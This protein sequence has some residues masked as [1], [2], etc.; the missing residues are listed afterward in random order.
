[1]DDSDDEKAP[2]APEAPAPA[3]PAAPAAPPPSMPADRGDIG[4]QVR[5]G[6]FR[7]GSHENIRA[8]TDTATRTVA[9]RAVNSGA[10]GATGPTNLSRTPGERTPPG[11]TPTGPVGPLG[12]RAA[13]VATATIGTG[14]AP[15]FTRDD[16]PTNTAIQNRAQLD[17]GN[18]AA[19][20]A[21]GSVAPPMPLTGSV[22]P[23]PP[24][25]PVT[26]AAAAPDDVPPTPAA[27][28][29]ASLKPI[30]GSLDVTL[31]DVT[32]E[33]YVTDQVRQKVQLERG[34]AL[35]TQDGDRIVT[36][37]GDA[38]LTEDGEGDW[39]PAPP[40]PATHTVAAADDVPVPPTRTG[41]AAGIENLSG[42][43][44]GKASATGPIGSRGDLSGRA[45]GTS[46]GTGIL[47][48]AE[49]TA[50]V[51]GPSTEARVAPPQDRPR[52]ES[53][54]DQPS[55]FDKIGFE[56][57]VDGLAQFLMS[58][59][60]KPPL[61]VSLEGEWGAGKSSFMAQLKKAIGRL[62][63][64]K[65]AD[66]ARPAKP[67][68]GG[69]VFVHAKRSGGEAPIGWRGSLPPWVNGL[70]T[71]CWQGLKIALWFAPKDA[72]AEPPRIIEFNAWRH[73]K[74]EAV[75]ASFAL[76]F[77][78]SA[79]GT[80]RYDRCRLAV[81]LAVK[82]FKWVEALPLLIRAGAL[83]L[84]GAAFV[85]VVG[86]LVFYPTLGD[87]S[88]ASL[89]TGW[90]DYLK[91]WVPRV[92]VASPIATGLLAALRRLLAPPLEIDLKKYLEVPAYK[93]K[94]SFLERFH[95][96]FELF[97]QTY[98]E[99]RR[100][101]VLVDDLDRC[102][103]T[104]GA[105]LLQ[106][107][108]MMLP[109]DAP[110][111]LIL[112]LDRRKLAIGVAVRNKDVLPYVGADSAAALTS[113]EDELRREMEPAAHAALAYGYEFIEK[114]IQLPF[115]VP[116]LSDA[117]LPSFLNSLLKLRPTSVAGGEQRQPE[118]PRLVDPVLE[119]GPEVLLVMNMVADAMGHNPRRLKQF[120][121][122]FRLRHYIAQETH[123]LRTPDD[124][125][126]ALRN[127][128]TR[129]RQA[130]REFYVAIEALSAGRRRAARRCERALMMGAGGG[131][132]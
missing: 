95:D 10:A 100:T 107:L 14:S 57:Y 36:E 121:N 54:N 102:E 130:R 124:G 34:G 8:P 78:R 132:A 106:A 127:V 83:A 30:T 43:A 59:G 66:G 80:G 6:E 116:Q 113:Q 40:A 31:G 98:L 118:E 61:T 29:G 35:L 96:D 49:P 128:S 23:A 89:Q 119:D 58:E 110:I 1:M 45:E 81:R 24:R 67:L 93:D 27:V 79:A 114:F 38:I 108:S 42:S 51:G 120:L 103:M 55:M 50:A 3:T 122:L 46:S 87:D 117:G 73:D 82:R 105:E 101:F 47:S 18:A 84:L 32:P 104:K 97:A 7:I 111:I 129:V 75:W 37:D 19:R 39:T 12:I 85:A 70:W 22:A 64:V 91:T 76:K 11:T 74:D 33:A 86:R 28:D 2:D 68:R 112:A 21:S 62:G 56:P 41:S 71:R 5:P 126:L 4:Y 9:S 52:P 123:Q 77:A 69:L 109:A 65:H 115:R 53:V 20:L 60:T 26:R 25:P 72:S 16:S 99:G 17:K 15:P 63:A 90:L 48:G 131:A 125:G 13:A 44:H 94:I 92:V 88:D